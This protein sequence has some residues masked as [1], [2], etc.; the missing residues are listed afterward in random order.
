[1]PKPGNSPEALAYRHAVQTELIRLFA[2]PRNDV[3]RRKLGDAVTQFCQAKVT[4]EQIGLIKARAEE[5]WS[6]DRITPM[7]LAGSVS[8]ALHPNGRRNGATPSEHLT[9]TTAEEIE[10]RRREIAANV[11]R[12]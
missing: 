7:G 4:V 9:A 2:D 6:P 10:E 12:S 3:E 1:V 5:S 11:R 8:V